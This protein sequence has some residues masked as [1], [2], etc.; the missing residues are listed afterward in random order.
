M[1]TRFKTLS[2]TWCL[3]TMA[4]RLHA[5]GYIVANGVSSA[6]YNGLFAFHVIQDPSSGN[7]T[8]F[9]FIPQN[10]DTF[11][12]ET[13]LDEGVRVFLVSPNDPVSLQPILANSYTELTFPNSYF[14][15]PGDPFY[16]GLYTGATFPQNGVYNDPLFGW[17]ELVN[18]N[19]TIQLLNGALEYGGGG[20]YAGTLTIIPIPE[21]SPM[22]L[23]ALSALLFLGL[24]YRKQISQ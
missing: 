22:A 24:K 6:D 1:K 12:F 8:D 14:L 13:A 21:P 4:L 16:V 15:S 18:N 10:A 3:F 23:L 20:I 9:V 7:F 19:G 2:L 11:R 5:Q 17:A